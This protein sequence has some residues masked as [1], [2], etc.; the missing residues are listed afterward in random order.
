[1]YDELILQAQHYYNLG[2]HEQALDLINKAL[3]ER[4]H[5][6]YALYMRAACLFDGRRYQEALEACME[7]SKAGFSPE[8]VHELFATIYNNIP[9]FA[10]A[11][12]HL[13]ETLRLNPQNVS[14]LAKY[15]LLMYETGHIEKSETLM[16]EAM[17]IDPFD[18]SVLEVKLAIQESRGKTENWQEDFQ[19]YTENA[20][21]E[22][23]RLIL[24]GNHHLGKKQ[25]G[26]AN[27][28]FRQAFLIHPENKE[29]LEILDGLKRELSPMF[30]PLRIFWYVNPAFVWVGC[31]IIVGLLKALGFDSV[32]VVF[33]SVYL[34][35]A[36]YTWLVRPL[37]KLFHRKQ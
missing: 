29:L 31:I 11:E 4:P 35:F 36:L 3:S 15:S 34:I 18:T 20:E 12:E 6:G 32:A 25:F 16:A 30:F 28:Y 23:N 17:K 24:L 26:K 19:N 7:S 33:V 10:K 27:E 21:S 2:K 9:N 5:D 37:Y 22:Y 13:L 14:A 1:M 8:A